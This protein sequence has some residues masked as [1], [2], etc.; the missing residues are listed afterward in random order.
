MKQTVFLASL[1]CA[2]FLIVHLHSQSSFPPTGGSGG[3]GATGPTGPAGATGATG[4]AGG[5]G[6]AGATGSTG[7]QGAP[8]LN[9]ANGAPGV[10]GYSPDQPV[11]GCGVAW[12]SGLTFNV[13][14]CTYLV[15]NVTYSAPAASLT[16]ATADPSN[17]RF[18]AIIVDTSGAASAI[19]GTPAATPVQPTVDESLQLALTYVYIPAGA[20]TPGNF[21]ST[22]IY[23]ENAGPSSEFTCTKSGTPIAL[24]STNNPYHGSVDI[25]A[26]AATTANY[27]N[28][29]AAAAFDPTTRNYLVFYIRSKA[30][31]P[32]ARRINFQLYLGATAEGSI[33]AFG[34]GSFG[35]SS[36]NTTSYQLIVIPLTS[37]GKI[38]SVDTLRWTI[39]G[40][41]GTFGFYYDFASLQSGLP[42]ASA[43]TAMTWKR[44]WNSTVS[45][46]VND[47]TISGGLPWVALIANTNSAPS[48]TNTNWDALT[49][50]GHSA[51][52][53][54]S[55][56]SAGSCTV[57]VT[58]SGSASG[59]SYSALTVNTIGTAA[60]GW[61]CGVHDLTN[62]QNM[63]GQSA[64]ATTTAS[65]LSPA[66][67]TSGDTVV[68][69][70]NPY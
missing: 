59:C 18:D 47:V 69:V 31:W 44:S 35:F 53:F 58:L 19:T 40:S 12:V 46:A 66:I 39:A 25:E 57:V 37:F 32:A 38:A 52:T 16:L 3:G 50:L 42:S 62:P 4:S 56:D 36:A 55:G 30:A 27:V 28:C 67:S 43:A 2:V 23:D 1:L 6:P 49:K 7:A 54:T 5:S 21:N 60:H 29:Q 15:A 13:A 34:D 33:V 22:L 14:A 45:Y 51:G 10:A 8:G 65:F 48:A 9:G 41:G 64:T 61:A 11:T 68:F 17:P 70:C 20:T 26:T 63:W 24:A